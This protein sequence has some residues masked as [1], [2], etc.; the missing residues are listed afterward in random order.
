MK[1]TEPNQFTVWNPLN[2]FL[3]L[4]PSRVSAQKG[5]IILPESQTKK[6]NQ[7]ICIK[8]AEC[9]S[10]FFLG[11]ECFFAA[12]TEYGIEDSETGYTIFVIQS[13][14][15]LMVREPSEEV[16]KHSIKKVTGLSFQ[17]IEHVSQ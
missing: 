16:A 3:V 2:G 9:D 13:D 17:T 15:I 6:S 14:K 10:P 11:K 7:G 12:H 1:I 5:S 4:L 8:C